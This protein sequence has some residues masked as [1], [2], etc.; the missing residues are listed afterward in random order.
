M[1]RRPLFL[2]LSLGLA[3]PTASPAQEDP[4]PYLWLEEVEGERA[5]DW[6][7]DQNAATLAALA[8]SAVYDSIYR[9]S[10]EILNSQDK[11]DYPR[12][13]GDRIYN[14]WQD[15]DHERGIWRRTGWE[16]YLTEDPAWETVLDIDSLAA[17]E[18]REV[19]N[20]SEASGRL[21]YF[22]RRPSLRSHRDVGRGEGV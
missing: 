1:S 20:R 9:A 21:G 6:V 18:C 17:R 3:L 16:S 15:A 12:I 13:M 14:F 2:A 11:I 8:G 19:W 5:L 4:D 22:G 7:E 10:L